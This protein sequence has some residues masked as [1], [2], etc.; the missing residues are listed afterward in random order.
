MVKRQASSTRMFRFILDIIP[1][2][3][4]AS[5]RLNYRRF[6]KRR[7]T[8]TDI[9]PMGMAY[10]WA[11]TMLSYSRPEGIPLL[12]HDFHHV[13]KKLGDFNAC[14]VGTVRH[15]K[16]ARRQK[17]GNRARVPSPPP[18]RPPLVTGLRTECRTYRAQLHVRRWHDWPQQLRMHNRRGARSSGDQL[19][20]DLH[21]RHG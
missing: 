12:F 18:P 10:E 9:L 4:T 2:C 8:L 7:P 1:A 20:E 17:A 15:L 11:L 19:P 6:L 3:C 16:D 5:P 21:Q 13:G 14:P